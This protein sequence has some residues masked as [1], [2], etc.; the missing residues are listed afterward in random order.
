MLFYAAAKAMDRVPDD[1]DPAGKVIP[2]AESDHIKAWDR[3]SFWVVDS[4]EQEAYLGFLAQR[5][6]VILEYEHWPAV[7]ALAEE[8]LRTRELGKQKIRAIIRAAMHSPDRQG[9]AE[10]YGHEPVSTEGQY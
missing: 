4:L 9:F 6:R 5:A 10:K 2:T 1:L 8:L 3:I 7:E